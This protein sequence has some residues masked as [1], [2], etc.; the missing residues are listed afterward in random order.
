MQLGLTVRVLGVTKITS[1]GRERL[2]ERENS[3][4]EQPQAPHEVTARPRRVEGPTAINWT[5]SHPDR[6][7]VAT[8]KD[9]L[10]ITDFF[11]AW[12]G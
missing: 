12:T 2:S 1:A 3:H 8:A 10:T 9:E 6:L 11:F 4:G 5:V 7:V